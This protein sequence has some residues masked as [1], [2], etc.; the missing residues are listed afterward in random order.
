MRWVPKITR[1]DA[2]EA[3][4]A[5]ETAHRAAQAKARHDE[6]EAA[7]AAARA[8]ERARIRRLAIDLR[9]LYWWPSQP[10]SDPGW[11]FSER[12]EDQPPE[13]DAC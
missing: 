13:R 12:L 9:A 7:A 11:P 8:A 6:L 10:L 3:A 1:R 4:A 2:R 5:R